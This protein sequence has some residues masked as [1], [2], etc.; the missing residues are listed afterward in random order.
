MGFLLDQGIKAIWLDIDG[1]LYPK[2]MLNWRM[3]KTVFPSFRLGL[4]FNSVRKEFRVRQELVATDPPN[5]EG[6]LVRQAGLVLEKMG[7]P[8]T[9]ENLDKT[10][11]KVDVQFYSKWEK[12]FLSIKPF[13]GLHEALSLAKAQGIFIGVFS[14]FPIAKKL[15]TL[16]I[17]DLVEVAISSEDSG[18]LK[19]SEKAFEYLL[20][21]KDFQPGEILY[22]GDSYD[23]DIL[24]AKQA[25]MYA[26]LLSRSKDPF[27]EAD[28]VA[29]SWEE[30]S[31]LV[32]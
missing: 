30:F 12:S 18:Y 10:M 31:S 7:K 25:G 8:I 32:L 23:K 19:P 14:D 15:Q 13:P 6:L 28:L 22:V 20:S 26:C 3:V 21:Q 4:L 2:R 16:G 1:T 5:R 24:G 27:P 9:P 17:E 29:R 11:R